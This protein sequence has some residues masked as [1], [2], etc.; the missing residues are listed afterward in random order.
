LFLARYRQIP[1]FGKDTIRRF[2]ANVS[3]MRRM[4]A[5]DL[6]DLLQ[7]SYHLLRFEDGLIQFGDIVLDTR[8]RRPPL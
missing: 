7:V 8:L 4:T 5:G 6:E 1:T 3:D 2:S